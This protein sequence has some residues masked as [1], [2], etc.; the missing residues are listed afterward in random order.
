MISLSSTS[1]GET[2]EFE[3]KDLRG[4][5][6]L[7]AFLAEVSQE[8]SRSRIKALIKSGHARI[9]GVTVKT[10][11]RPVHEGQIVTLEVPAPTPLEIIPSPVPFDIVFQDEEIAVVNKPA[12]IV[13]H[14]AAGNWDGTLVH[15][16]L[17][18]LEGLSGIGGRLRPG[19]VHRLDKETS[20]LLIVAKN[21]RAHVSLVEAFK[22][23]RIKKEYHALVRGGLRGKKGRMDG[24][25]GR[26]PANRKKMWVVEGGK[27]AITVWEEEEALRGA[28]LLRIKLLTGR[29]HQIRVHMAHAGHP[30]LGDRLYGGPPCLNRGGSTIH[31]PRQMLHAGAIRFNHP[32]TST[33]MEF[34]APLPDDLVQVIE[35]LR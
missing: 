1:S 20:G 17:Q 7:D 16:L 33:A 19:I 10:P 23:G 32:L 5:I 34:H 2:I 30:L 26:H 8:L 15:G 12:G 14:P 22:A 21:D 28:T 11:S 35:A 3:A 9:D 29:T 13:T 18:R 4:K 25:I 27:K 24:P 31:I 6:R